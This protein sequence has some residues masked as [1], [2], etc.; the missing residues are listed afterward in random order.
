[1]GAS[2]RACGSLEEGS[3]LAL[4]TGI[5]R[6]EEFA[7]WDDDDIEAGRRLLVT[8]QFPCEAFG[9]VPNDGA[10]ETARGGNSEPRNPNG[11]GRDEHGHETSV[12]LGA[13]VVGQFKVGPAPHVLASPECDH[14]RTAVRIGELRTRAI[15]VQRQRSSETVRRFRPLARRRLSTCCPF[16]VAIRTRNPCV[17]LRRRLFGWNVRTPLG[18]EILEKLLILHQ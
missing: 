9:A 10:A 4:E 1:V 2:L 11:V 17:R 18:I 13:A 8:E 14:D 7:A 6:I 16:L 3:K 15:P 5:W 12:D